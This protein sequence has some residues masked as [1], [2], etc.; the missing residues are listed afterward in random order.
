M[1]QPIES[2]AAAAGTRAGAPAGAPS[3]SSAPSAPNVSDVVVIGGGAAGLNAALQLARQARSVLVLDAGEPRNAP[4]SHLHGLL[5]HDGLPPAELLAKGRA[6]VRSYG[7]EVVE[8]RVLRAAAEGEGAQ[9]RFTLTLAD[10]TE[11]LARAVVLA[12]GLVDRLPE[13]P[14]LAERWGRD[15]LHCPYCHGWEVRDRRIA[16]LASHPNATHQALLFARLGSSAVL[17]THGVDLAESDAALLEAAGVELVEGPVAAVETH[18]DALAGLRL[19][20]GGWVPADAVVVQTR[21]EARLGGLEGLGLVA[22]EHPSGMGTA[23]EV[24]FAGAT[25]V[26]GVWAAGNVTDPAAQLGAA[27]AAGALAGAGVNAA[28]TMEDAHAVLAAAGDRRA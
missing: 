26:P 11:V 21:M 13:I 9:R 27:A 16:I 7:G 5:G 2:N 12:S 20:G 1:N 3:E 10:G 28:L 22:A 19:E 18:D 23:V 15:A 25:Q 6:E 8:G 17:V 4:A 14:G 24:G